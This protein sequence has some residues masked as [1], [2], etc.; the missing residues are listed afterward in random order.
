[1]KVYAHRGYSGMYPENTML[2][3]QKA[4]ETGCDGIELDVQTTKDGVAV[5]IH[6][7]S[8]DRTTDGTGLVKD[9]TYEELV[10]FNAGKNFNDKYGFQT[11]PT[12]EEYCR[13][14]RQTNLVTNVEL[15]TSIYYYK[16]LEEKTM[17]LVR[18][19]DLTDRMLYS[20]F[21]HMS[22]VQIKKIDS[23]VTAVLLYP[24]EGIGNAGYYCEKSGFDAYHPGVKGLTKEMVKDCREHGI[25]VNVWTVNDMG[26]L[27]RLYEWGCSGIFTN[28]PSVCKSWLDSQR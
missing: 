16:E 13:W 17:E 25:D 20:S 1:M 11:I 19:Y 3:F 27:E 6:D 12:F 21:N 14:V 22:L 5:V 7:E 10:K 15:K 26:A 28:H 4:E 9:Y 18:R 23:A 8:I 2:A 24:M